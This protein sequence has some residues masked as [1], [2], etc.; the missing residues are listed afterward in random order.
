MTPKSKETAK[1]NW[2]EIIMN[3][4]EK[5][6]LIYS[7]P[8][9][10]GYVREA[11]EFAIKEYISN[12]LN[13]DQ[14]KELALNHWNQIKQ[15]G[16]RKRIKGVENNLKNLELI[17][18]KKVVSLETKERLIN[19]QE[20]EIK[21]QIPGELKEIYLEMASWMRGKYILKNE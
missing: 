6:E 9:I 11:H 16:E 21:A 3:D 19:H 18:E 13:E 12:Y 1:K 14:E 7:D 2:F 17:L 10:K 15:E 8:R 20:E 4:I 5:R